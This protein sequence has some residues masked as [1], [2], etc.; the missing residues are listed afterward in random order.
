M[1][2]YVLNQTG[3]KKTGYFGHSQGTTSFWVLCSMRPEYNNKITMMH[4]L[5]PVAY[6]KHVKSPLLGMAMNFVK[7]SKGHLNELLPRNEMLYKMCTTSK[8]AED[9]CVDVFFKIAGKDVKQ[10]NMASHYFLKIFKYE[11]KL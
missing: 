8:I 6:M 4:A 1:I 5:A 3:Y 10:T 2:D 7:A 11:L 9:T